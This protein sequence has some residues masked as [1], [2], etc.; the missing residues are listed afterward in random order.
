MT[1]LRRLWLKIMDNQS[2][3]PKRVLTDANLK[4]HWQKRKKVKI[5]LSIIILLAII[6]GFFY[7]YETQ[8]VAHKKGLEGNNGEVT[9][10][11]PKLLGKEDYK[12]EDRA[13]GKYILADSLG[14]SAKIPSGWRVEFQTTSPTDQ[15]EYFV[16]LYS[17]DVEMKYG[18]I[19]QGCGISLSAGQNIEGNQDTKERIAILKGE[20]QDTKG[21]MWNNRK[22]EIITIG[23]K[24]S[25]K[26]SSLIKNDAGNIVGEGISVPINNDTLL[27]IYFSSSRISQDKCIQIWEEM[28]KNLKI[29]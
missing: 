14:L 9:F 27:N 23:S 5:I 17:P 11:V 10:N 6:G 1:Q 18:I 3:A 19:N 8:V 2:F 12:V 22:Y 16:N 26:T 24:E 29:Q 15:S 7:W 25:L 28:L 20:A 21:L 13:D 4:N